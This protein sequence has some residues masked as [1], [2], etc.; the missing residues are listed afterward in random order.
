SNSSSALPQL[1]FEAS[2][3]SAYDWAYPV[4]FSPIGNLLVSRHGTEQSTGNL[5]FWD[6]GTCRLVRIQSEHVS[7]SGVLALSPD[8][9]TMGIGCCWI[10]EQGFHGELNLCDL[11]TG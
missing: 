11:A 10:S 1:C 6:A 7:G 4:A 5:G 3:Q 8:G 9:K 2:K